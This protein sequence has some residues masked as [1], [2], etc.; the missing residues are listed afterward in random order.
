MTEAMHEKD[1]DSN[2]W[3][4]ERSLPVKI[5][6]VIGFV[7]LGA[8]LLFLFGFIVRALWNWLMPDIFGLKTITYWQA[9]GLLV[10]SCILFGRIGGSGGSG[11]SSDRKRKKQLRS[12]IREEQEREAEKE[13]A[14][15]KEEGPEE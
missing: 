6:M 3:W 2:A 8:G 1:C 7:I 15:E 12:Y 14:A 10:L 11:G 9:W 5:L 4:E 13:E